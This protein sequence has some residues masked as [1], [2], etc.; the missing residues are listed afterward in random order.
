MR[1]RPQPCSCSEARGLATGAPLVYHAFASAEHPFDA[2]RRIFSRGSSKSLG[3]DLCE[4]RLEEYPPAGAAG[5]SG[6][7]ADGELINPAGGEL[8]VPAGRE[9]ASLLGGPPQSAGTGAA[10]RAGAWE[11]PITSPTI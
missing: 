5:E 1:T 3:E 7:M 11:R 6:E 8:M 2:A 10:D 9:R 4:F